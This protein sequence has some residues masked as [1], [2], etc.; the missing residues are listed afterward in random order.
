MC[1]ATSGH[2]DYYLITFP[3]VRAGPSGDSIEAGSWDNMMN[4]QSLVPE[5]S[6][7]FAIAGD[8]STVS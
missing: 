8:S 4:F 1:Y 7:V 2:I 3:T 5:S 6:Q